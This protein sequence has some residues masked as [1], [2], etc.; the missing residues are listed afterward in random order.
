MKV[1]NAC[2]LE[3]DYEQ[4]ANDW[5]IE[6]LISEIRLNQEAIA[7]LEEKIRQAQYEIELITLGNSQEPLF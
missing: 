5:R 2:P 7:E 3:E 4:M 1:E 6:D